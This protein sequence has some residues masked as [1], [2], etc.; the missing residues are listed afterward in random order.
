[1][2]H[3]ISQRSQGN[4]YNQ[5]RLA[6]PS[7][8]S[9]KQWRKKEPLGWKVEMLQTGHSVCDSPKHDCAH[10]KA[11]SRRYFWTCLSDRRSWDPHTLTLDT[12]DGSFER[13]KWLALSSRGICVSAS[14]LNA[15]Q[16]RVLVFCCIPWPY[17]IFCRV[18][19][20]SINNC[21]THTTFNDYHKPQRCL[22]F[23]YCKEEGKILCR[24]IFDNF[25]S[26]NQSLE[27]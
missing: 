4:I 7:W 8:T 26:T 15:E 18:S 9:P 23:P 10:K 19:H 17:R 3:T 20:L 22:Y 13:D 12:I 25:G 5:G 14:A 6:S 16:I 1:M 21:H 2:L 27:K 24:Q 11:Q